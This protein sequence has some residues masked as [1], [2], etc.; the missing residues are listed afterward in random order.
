[1]SVRR[2]ASYNLIGS[3]I[4]VALSLLTVPI[5]LHQVGPDRYGVLAISWLLLGY[6]GLFDL[7]LGRAT[8]FRIASLKDAPRDVRAATFWSALVVNAGMGVVGGVVLWL[9]AGYFF[10]HVLKTPEHLRPEI[11]A[12]V[13]MLAAAV[14]IATL[15]GVL[16]GA[17]QGREKFLETNMISVFSTAL[18]QLLPLAVALSLGP[19]LPR[20]LAAAVFARLLAILVLAYRCHVEITSGVRPKFD[21]REIPQ[22][23]KFGGWV[24]LTSIVGPVLVI[25][26]RFA[27][28]A[29]LSTAALAVYTVPFQLVQ[30]VAIFPSALTNALFPRMTSV[31]ADTREVLS[32]RATLA[33]ACLVSPIILAGILALEPFLHLWIGPKIG[34]QA[35]PIGRILL[36][37]FWFNAFALVPFTQLQASGRPDLPPKMH[38]VEIPAYLTA[39]YL[40]MKGLGLI[41]CA[42]AFSARCALD[43][44]LLSAAAGKRS[45]HQRLLAINLAVLIAAAALCEFWT[46]RAL[47]WWIAATTLAGFMAILSWV[48][49]PAD[50]R[51]KVLGRLRLAR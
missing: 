12:A 35:A 15:T 51:N 1:M 20:L 36:I 28:G 33:L 29:V 43:F 18:F 48:N 47:E 21:P 17:M 2:H 9:A 50:L 27:I 26:D 4:P 24:N 41:G 23:L 49:L 46:I 39:L 30:R 32:R 3:I 37:G 11:M 14:P 31:D 44:V 34:E 42:L 5:Y 13:P 38:L 8:S 19:Y 10:Q 16:S 25:V 22:L 6:F 40:G 45:H 7:G